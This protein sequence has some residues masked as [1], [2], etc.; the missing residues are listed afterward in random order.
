M[1]KAA[2]GEGFSPKEAEAATAAPWQTIAKVSGKSGGAPVSKDDATP[3][4]DPPP[5]KGEGEKE[6]VGNP[7][8]HFPI[9]LEIVPPTPAP[10]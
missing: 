2:A 6:A 9:I 5:S 10:V 4:P 1:K 3:T 7:A 8:C